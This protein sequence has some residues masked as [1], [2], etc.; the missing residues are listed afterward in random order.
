MRHRNGECRRTLSVITKWMLFPR[1]TD[2][3]HIIDNV[4]GILK[5]RVGYR[6]I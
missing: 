1:K 6:L 4:R 3:C 2:V 5:Q